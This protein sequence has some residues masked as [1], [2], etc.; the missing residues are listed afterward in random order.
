[1]SFYRRHLLRHLLP[2]AM[3]QTYPVPI[4][5]RVIAAPKGACWR[6]VAARG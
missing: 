2:F 1:M 6:S 3:R 5:T 4:R